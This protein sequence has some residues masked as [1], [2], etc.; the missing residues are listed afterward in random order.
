MKVRGELVKMYYQNLLNAVEAEIVFTAEILSKDVV[1]K[2]C[3]PQVPQVPQA[4]PVINRDRDGQL[5]L[6]TLLRKCRTHAGLHDFKTHVNHK[7]H[8]SCVRYIQKTVLKLLRSV[9]HMLPYLY[10]R[11]KMLQLG[12]PQVRIDFATEFLKR[13]DADNN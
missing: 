4:A 1:R 11:V 13:C 7:K 3:V 8:S 2:V 10:Q 9:F 6:R 5:F 12:D